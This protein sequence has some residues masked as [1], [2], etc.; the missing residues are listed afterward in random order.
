MARRFSIGRSIADR[1]KP[2]LLFQGGEVRSVRC[3]IGLD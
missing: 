2:V 3:P 1:F